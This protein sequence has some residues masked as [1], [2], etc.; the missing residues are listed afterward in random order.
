MLWFPWIYSTAL[1]L[2]QVWPVRGITQAAVH[3]WYGAHLQVV[4][5]G[6]LGL[7]AVFYCVP[8]LKQATLYSRELALF[9]LVGVL[10]FGGWVGLAYTVPLPAWMGAIGKVMT[11]FLLL[12]VW[13][14]VLNLR[15]TRGTADA[16]PELKFFSFGILALL[17]FGVLLA[18]TRVVPSGERLNFTVAQQALSVLLVAGFSGVIG[19][20][21]A[22]FILPR[23]AGRP[24]PSPGLVRLHFWIAALAVVLMAVAL[25][26]G[27]FPHGARLVDAQ[28]PFNEVARAYLM[29]IRMTSLGETLWILGALLFAVNVMRLIL[30]LAVGHVRQLVQGPAPAPTLA[31]VRA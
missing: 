26:A 31:E 20:G 15:R 14:T 5:L 27:G 19:L 12:P 2:L 17:I 11:L 22:Y 18:F 28:V 3:G 7:A 21:G 8:V 1:L 6:L 4:L 13:A 29:S 25:F 23:I 10:L 16:G 30:A 9:T 24:L